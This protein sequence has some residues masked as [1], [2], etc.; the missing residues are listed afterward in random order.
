MAVRAAL[1]AGR[2]RIARQ[3]LTES[4]L[5][6]IAGSA[7]GLVLASLGID[8]LV[9]MLPA[10]VPRL[11]QVG[12]DG[13][14]LA[15]TLLV[16]LLTGVLFGVAP[17]LRAAKIDLNDALKRGG[18]TS[19]ASAGRLRRGLVVAEVAL[20]LVLLIGAGLLGLSFWRIQAVDT[21]LRR[22]PLL[23]LQLALPESRYPDSARVTAFYETLLSRLRALPDAQSVGLTSHVPL[24]SGGFRIGV[25]ILGRPPV[26][27]QQSPA[28]RY[29]AVSANYFATLGVP[30]VAGR[31]LDERDRRGGVRVAVI[32]QTM[33]QRYWTKENP[34]GQR[35]TL[36]DNDP[37][38][39]EIVGVVTDVKHFG[40]VAENQPEFFM[41]FAQA[42]DFL[43][44][45]GLNVV[46]QPRGDIAY[47]LATV[48]ST[49]RSLDPE[50]PLYRVTTLQQLHRESVAM[51]RV[52]GALLGSFALAAL[53]LAAIGIYGVIAYT[54]AQRQREIGVRIALGA[55]RRDVLN[56]VVGDGVRLAV[57][58]AGLGLLG[59]LG[60]TRLIAA[61]LYNVSATDPEVF[62]GVTAVLIAIA[63]LACW[64]PARRAA[65]L[66][67]MVALRTE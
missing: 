53:L 49:L 10:A 65:K 56:L 52:Y 18:R 58:G 5:L 25:T 8:R 41:P 29:R 19:C 45:R 51:P 27:P 9:G 50:L 35:F 47:A 37:T 64:L 3:L 43:L 66:D 48:R 14:V 13:P 36:D 32:N 54:V 39:A 30:V 55:S 46:V 7:L 28:A 33:A 57:L 42:S 4:L 26:S 67:P 61:Q 38:P 11:G 12:I 1:G 17:S 34:I 24:D 44:S 40:P 15:F 63:L 6:A 60:L 62:I 16:A 20:A 22:E 59:A 23:A 31:G 2:G 21:G